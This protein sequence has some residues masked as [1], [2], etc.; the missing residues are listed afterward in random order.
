MFE[1]AH[2]RFMRDNMD[3]SLTQ[4]GLYCRPAGTMGTL[5]SLWMV[6]WGEYPLLEASLCHLVLMNLPLTKN[7]NSSQASSFHDLCVC[8]LGTQGALM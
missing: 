2:R 6:L 1:Q 8:S 5:G 4:A 3:P 7:N